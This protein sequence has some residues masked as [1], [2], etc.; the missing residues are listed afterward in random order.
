MR[1]SVRNP[2]DVTSPVAPGAQVRAHA[3][4]CT[5]TDVAASRML[6][7]ITAIQVPWSVTRERLQGDPDSK[8]TLC[9]KDLGSASD[10]L[11]FAQV[12]LWDL[13]QAARRRQGA[14][15]DGGKM[16]RT[17]GSCES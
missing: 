8:N 10:Q 14:S 17:V 3:C 7:L 2:T 9:R 11:N 6:A 1:T 13:S 4:T 16:S 15:S 5:L 12:L